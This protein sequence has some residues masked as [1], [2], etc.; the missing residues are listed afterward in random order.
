[1]NKF[2]SGTL[3]VAQVRATTLTEESIKTLRKNAEFVDTDKDLNEFLISVAILHDLASMT[4]EDSELTKLY[5]ESK[6]CA[7]I[8]IMFI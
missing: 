4:A 8:H 7:Y 3:Q 6:G 5:E 1:M 2:I